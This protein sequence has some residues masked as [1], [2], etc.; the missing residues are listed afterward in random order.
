ME[1][2]IFQTFTRG[3]GDQNSF[4]NTTK[5]FQKKPC[6]GLLHCSGTFTDNAKAKVGKRAGQ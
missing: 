5:K 2:S 1:V 3:L 6:C 4:H